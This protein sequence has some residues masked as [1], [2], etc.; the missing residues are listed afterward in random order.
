MKGAEKGRVACCVFQQNRVTLKLDVSFTDHSH[1]IGRGGKN[2]QEIMRDTACHIHFPDANKD[3]DNDK[4][5]QVNRRRVRKKSVSRL[6]ML[7]KHF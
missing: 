4:S 7:I 1:I 3:R 6:E 5:N 2:T